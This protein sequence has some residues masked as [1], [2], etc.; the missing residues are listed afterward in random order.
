MIRNKSG[1]RK[2]Y[3]IGYFYSVE[4]FGE[5]WKLW[6]T[7]SEEF[8][9]C[10]YYEDHMSLKDMDL[11][12][13]EINFKQRHGNLDRDRTRRR[14]FGRLFF[15]RDTRRDCGCWQQGLQVQAGFS[16]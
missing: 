3:R 11:T 9:Q 1:A 10:S 12:G 16:F 7:T 14:S 4:F 8:L 5:D 15:G 13:Y 6:N 2:L